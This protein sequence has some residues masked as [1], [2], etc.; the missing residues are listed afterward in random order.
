MC[1]TGGV[2]DSPETGDEA[3]TDAA[4]TALLEDSAEDLYESAPCGYLSTLMDGTIAKINN[5]LLDWL[6]LDRE[7]VA[8]RKRFADLLT[9]GGKLYHETHFA[10]LLRMQGELRGIALDMRRQEGGP[11]PVLVSAVI[12]HGSEGEPLLI[13]I[14]V[15]DASDRRSYEK[16]LL[17]RRKEAERAHAEADEAR[18]QAEA[19]R[20]RLAEALA[21]L[22]RSLV[23]DSLPAVPG[24]ETA[25][26]YHTAAPDQLGGDFYDLFPVS[27]GRWAF[28][29]GDVCGKGPEAASLTSLTRYTL[30][31]AAHHDPDPAS[32]LTTLNAVLHE[33]YTGDG[34]P[35]YCT[36]I[37]GII[38]PGGDHGPTTVRLASGGH[39]PALVLRS[40]GRA[41]YLPTP[42]GLL[43][44]VLPSAPIGTAETVLAPGDT[45]VLYTDGLTEART[46]PGRDDLYGE[47]ALH[48]FATDHA[49][50][51]PDEVIIALTGLLESFGDG[52]DDDTALLALG[53]PA[54][55]SLIAP[56]TTSHAS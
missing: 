13:R 5:T 17:H 33:R 12:K 30:R 10:P 39:P 29:L 50:A 41:E 11:L 54:A 20:A 35:R 43:I 24:V 37:F 23:P 34:D 49:P 3:S 26:H 2:P 7:A 9:I 38:E 14:T 4:F 16:E 18:R 47:D 46:G 44:G 25:V 27:G 32:A 52:L 51:S 53:V 48:A 55:P 28:F 56:S 36:C 42:G 40:D 8:G 31:A 15:F 6:G 21:V 45:V 22:Q 19:D 1:R